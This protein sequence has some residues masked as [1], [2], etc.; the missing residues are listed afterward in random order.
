MSNQLGEA[1]R[2]KNQMLIS[3]HTVAKA[4]KRDM[5]GRAETS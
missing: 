5:G 2:R 3:D 4:L 1:E